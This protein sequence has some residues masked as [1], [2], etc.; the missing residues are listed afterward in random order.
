MTLD[1]ITPE[2]VA[3]VK[4]HAITFDPVK[5]IREHKPLPLPIKPY[6]L[7][8]GYSTS[9]SIDILL[10][11]PPVHHVSVWHKD[12]KTDPADAELIAAKILGAV[13]ISFGEY[14]RRDVYHFYSCLDMKLLAIHLNGLK[15]KLNR[16][17]K[18]M[19][20]R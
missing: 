20:I 19:G 8:S 9:Y 12:G 6:N 13:Y 15:K 18:K 16:L 14:S 1:L 2:E 3:K 11:I 5:L 10:G 17:K 4:A 7:K